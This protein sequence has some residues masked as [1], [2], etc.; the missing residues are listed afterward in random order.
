MKA[1]PYVLNVS[2]SMLALRMSDAA[3][4]CAAASASRSL[5]SKSNF[6][7]RGLGQSALG[8]AVCSLFG[9]VSK[10]ATESVSMREGTGAS[11]M[12][13]SPLKPM[14][15]L[16]NCTMLNDLSYQMSVP[17]PWHSS[18]CVS[19][20]SRG[21]ASESDSTN[22]ADSTPCRLVALIARSCR[23]S[24]ASA[25]SDRPRH[26]IAAIGGCSSP[27]RS[28]ASASA[29]TPFNCW[30]TSATRSGVPSSCAATTSKI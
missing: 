25:H 21:V 16:A 6:R 7:C 10:C 8:A 9:M 12:A 29:T 22:M 24:R 23:C 30:S 15:P 1:L 14:R 4:A 5:S 27:R 18:R 2:V 19:V 28:S 11:D 17:S 26:V 13:C 20:P 3:D